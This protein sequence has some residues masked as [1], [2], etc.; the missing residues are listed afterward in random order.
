MPLLVTLMAA[1]FGCAEESPSTGP[2]AG[3][4]SG[5]PAE[6]EQS[7]E[8]APGDYR[9]F[10]IAEPKPKVDGAIRV[11]SYNVLNLFDDVD[12]PT[13]SGRQEDIDDTKPEAHARAVAETIRRIDPDILC[14]QE[15]ENEAA[16][17]AFVDAYLAD[18]GYDHILSL[19]AGDA[20]GIEQSVLSR[21]PIV[22]SEQWV[23]MPLGGVHPDEYGDQENWYAGEDITYHRSPLRADVRV[24][25]PGTEPYD[26][27][28]F[29]LHCKSGRYSSYWREAE[30][31]ALAAELRE[32][33]QAEPERNILVLGDF[34]ATPDQASV[35]TYLQAGFRDL[36]ESAGLGTPETTT[37]ESGRRIDYMLFNPALAPEIVPGSGHVVGTPALPEGRSWREPWR[38]DG[39]AA[40]HYPVIVDI[41]AAD[42]QPQPGA[43]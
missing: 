43:S 12:D 28:L 22:G 1:V 7:P 11:V 41:L 9:R 33:Q 20:R 4:A 38:P 25:R 2:Q 23:R 5:P 34:N 19:D 40:D 30:A 27:T 13:L 31:Q 8:S 21:F 42:S 15:V 35:V 10:G 37:H 14:L 6:T 24:D 32:V 26:I 17:R 18:M 16:L 39:Y 29:V 36:F 3:T